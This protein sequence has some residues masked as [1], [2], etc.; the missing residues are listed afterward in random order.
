MAQGDI[1]IYASQISGH[2]W[3]PNGAMDALA[4]VSPNGTAGTVTFSG[5]PQG[6]KHLQIRMFAKGTSTS[7]GVNTGSRLQFNGDTTDTNYYR[8]TL[9]GNGSSAAAAA[10]NSSN[11]I[12]NSLGSSGTANVYGINIIDILDYA[13]NTKTKVVRNLLGHDNN[14]SG[15]VQLTSGLWNNTAPITSISFIAD[16]TYITNWASNSSFALY[17]IK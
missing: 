5:I 2:L 9:S 3:A 7:G 16:A 15:I 11:E 14:G 13:S 10:T 17:G 12:I 4:T 1:G 6:Y 8:H